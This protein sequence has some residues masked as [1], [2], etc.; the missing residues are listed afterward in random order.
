[1]VTSRKGSWQ[2][3][4]ERMTANFTNKLFYI[5]LALKPYA[6]L[7]TE[8]TLRQIHIIEYQIGNMTTKR[9]KQNILQS[10]I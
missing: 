8:N 9:K 5:V 4:E 10:V 1:M 2:G 7:K 6:N 3:G